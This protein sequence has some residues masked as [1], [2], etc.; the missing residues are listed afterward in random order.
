MLSQESFLIRRIVMLLTDPSFAAAC[1]EATV[2]LR[3][4]ATLDDLT[5]KMD[6]TPGG[7]GIYE[8]TELVERFTLDGDG[9]AQETL[10]YDRAG[11]LTYDGVFKYQYDAWNRMTR[12]TKAYRDDA[13]TVQTGSVLQE[14]EYDG[15]GRRV[16][17]RILNSGDLDC[18]QHLYYDGWSLVEVRNGSDITTSQYVWAGR[19]GGYIDELVQLAHNLD[20]PTTLDDTCETAY[21]AMQDA[22]YNVLGLVNDT[23]KLVERYEYEPYGERRVYVSTG[24]NDPLATAPIERSQRLT[25]SDGSTA[26][27]GLSQFGHQGLR[28]DDASGLIYNR[29]R[30]LSPIFGGLTQRDGLRYIDSA[31]LYLYAANNPLNYRDPSGLLLVA[32]DGTS[33]RTFL[34]G[35]PGTATGRWFSHTRNFYDDYQDGPKAYWFGPDAVSN[36]RQAGREVNG[37]V[38][39]AKQWICEQLCQDSEQ[40]I[41]LIGHSRGAY[42][43][44]VLAQEIGRPTRCC[45]QGGSFVLASWQVRF[46]GMY[47][48]VDMAWG[49]QALDTVSENVKNAFAVYSHPDMHSRESFRRVRGGAVDPTVTSYESVEVYATH[50]GLG[51]SPWDNRGFQDRL[52]AI[53]SDKY[54]RRAARKA[55]V[56]IREHVT[57]DYGYELEK[58]LGR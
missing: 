8:T 45:C 30:M 13:G 52:G 26:T 27:H 39:A 5:L 47:E 6:R 14:N 44:Q 24:S 57:S 11:N 58:W 28:H 7:D 18:T 53:T 50:S 2:G 17:V 16:V 29:V 12:V 48:P 51:G 3:S 1:R 9:L 20:W 21:W 36:F 49:V 34:A 40:P 33:T 41:D 43:V 55:G 54:M 38:A 25:L 23:G 31:N 4:R 15:L 37:I 19:V 10:E 22:N 42:A 56:P 32:I 35:G 46:L